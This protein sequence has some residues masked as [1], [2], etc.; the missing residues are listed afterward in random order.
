L[1]YKSN[2][3][4]QHKLLRKILIGQD[5]K[6]AIQSEYAEYESTWKMLNMVQTEYESTENAE[7]GP[8]MP[9][10][11]IPP[12]SGGEQDSPDEGCGR[13]VLIVR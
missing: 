11:L 9:M 7:Y 1:K 12:P 4:L 13:G 8:D 3:D 10:A 2:F 6:L 5:G